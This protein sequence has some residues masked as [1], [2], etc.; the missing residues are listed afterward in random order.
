MHG[1]GVANRQ[2]FRE[3][4]VRD[5]MLLMCGVLR[6]DWESAVAGPFAVRVDAITVDAP[7]H[8]DEHKKPG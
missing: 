6:V 3:L 8:D 5:E 2:F 7:G 1:V 4:S